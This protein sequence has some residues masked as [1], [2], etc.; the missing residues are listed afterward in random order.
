MKHID[1]QEFVL[2]NLRINSDFSELKF[3]CSYEEE[4]LLFE[5]G[6]CRK[7]DFG[8]MEMA[9]LPH[10]FS[11][12]MKDVGC[13]CDDD[14]ERSRILYPLVKETTASRNKPKKSTI[15]CKYFINAT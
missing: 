1:L 15:H 4:W 14:F 2:G 12:G 9:F 7:V 10:G 8:V 11:P 13:G 3:P 6:N 5:E